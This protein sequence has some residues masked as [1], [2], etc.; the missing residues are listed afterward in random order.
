MLCA[1]FGIHIAPRAKRMTRI[2]VE[3]GAYM[4]WSIK[5]AKDL[6]CGEVGIGA[7]ISGAE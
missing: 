4:W 6:A 7:R 5:Q 1:D 2:V 3:L